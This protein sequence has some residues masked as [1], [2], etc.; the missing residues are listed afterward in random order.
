M[1]IYRRKFKNKEQ[2]NIPRGVALGNFDGIHKGHAALIKAL[3]ENCK[4]KN[5]SSCVYTF[6][7]HPNNIIF[8]DNHTSV[9]MTEKEKINTLEKFFIDELF[10]EHFDEEYGNTSPDDFVEK[11][12]IEKLN[13]KLILVGY[14]YSYGKYGKGNVDS[15][16]KAQEKYGFELIVIPPVTQMVD[17][18][19]ITVASTILRKFIK[20]GNMQDFYRM[21]GRNYM[22]PGK[23][24]QGRNVGRKLGFPTANILPL[25]GF[26]LPSFGV[27]ATTTNIKNK[28]FRSITNIGNNPTFD[29][30]S[31]VTIETYILGF[32]G[33]LY[34]QDIEVEFIKKIRGEIAFS[35]P[36]ELTARISADV[37]ERTAMCE[38]INKIYSEDGIEIYHIPNE[39][40]KSAGLR[41][42]ICDNLSKERAYK[43]A[44]IPTILYAGSKKYPT[45]NSISKKMQE[46]YGAQLGID[47]SSSGEV[48]YGIYDASYTEPSYALEYPELE[49]EII[50]T[51]FEIIS[52][53]LTQEY[54]NGTGFVKDIFEREVTNRNNQINSIKNNKDSY[55]QRR[56]E[57]IMCEG[58]PMAVYMLGNVEDSKHITPTELYNYYKNEYLNESVIKVIYSG[59]NYP[60]KLTKKVVDLF[61][62]KKRRNLNPSYLYKG[63]ILEKDIKSV[64]EK[65]NVIQGKLFL[66]Y[67]TNTPPLSEEFYATMLCTAILGEGTQSKMFVNI[68]EKNSLAYYA[69]AYTIR[70]KGILYAYCGVDPANKDKAIGLIKE[71]I[72]AI[73]K[74]DFTDEERLAALKL[75]SHDLISYSDSQSR[76]TWY[77]LNQSMLGEMT[78][79]Q[80]YVRRLSLVTANQISAAAARMSLDTIYFLTGEGESEDEQI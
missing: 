33:E 34:G 80:E 37:Q 22:I 26:A 70:S 79:P 48:Q 15:L 50:D 41:I 1:E 36:E 10:L 78:D 58:E 72:E 31:C 23:V 76:T 45:I 2:Q 57:E 35:S 67:R 69:A 14:D 8:K 28:K 3:V 71:Q 6:E 18:R 64:E 68:R 47:A 20:D 9:I 60:E 27:Y 66:G 49:N 59:Q 12:L 30:V 54:E 7:N 5:L 44:L 29:D 42:A 40:F 73:K 19:E 61:G 13:A 16:R 52:N 24:L 56:C 4:S 55:A 46:L 32:D 62:G 63:E 25:P 43:N 65:Q 53:P 11:I 17:S 51:V 77:Y 38:G 75:I 74:G 39:K 21:A